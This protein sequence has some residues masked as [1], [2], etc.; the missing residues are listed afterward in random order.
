MSSSFTSVSKIIKNFL[1]LSLL[2]YKKKVIIISSVDLTCL[3]F[4]KLYAMHNWEFI[5]S[6]YINYDIVI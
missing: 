1:V 3:E 2:L 4:I 5:R 6:N